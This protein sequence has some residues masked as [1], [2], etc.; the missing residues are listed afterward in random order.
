[1]KNTPVKN[2]KR[3]ELE[4]FFLIQERYENDWNLKYLDGARKSRYL[5]GEK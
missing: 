3:D 1:M 5:E 2:F 4:K